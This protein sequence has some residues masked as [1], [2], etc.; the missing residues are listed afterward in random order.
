MEKQYSTLNTDIVKKCHLIV[1]VKSTSSSSSETVKNVLANLQAAG[2]RVAVRPASETTIFVFVQAPEPLIHDL[3]DEDRKESF[4]CGLL[5]RPEDMDS[6]GSCL[7]EPSEAL[8][9]VFERLT[10]LQ[11]KVVWEWALGARLIRTLSK[12][13]HPITKHNVKAHLGS[14]V[15]LYFAFMQFYFLNLVV[16]SAWGVFCYYFLGDYS[17]IFAFGILL[18]GIFFAQAWKVRERSLSQ[19]WSINGC[20]RKEKC[21]QEFKPLSFKVDSFTGRARP[22]FPQWETVLRTLP[23]V[24]LLLVSGGV[25]LGL[26]AGI[27]ALEVYLVELYNGPLKFLLTLLPTVAFQACTI[28]FFM[29]YRVAAKKLT[30]LENRRTEKEY[31]M[32]FSRKVF[33]FN[34]MVS[35]TA[36][37]LTAYVYGPFSKR[38]VAHYSSKLNV[39]SRFHTDSFQGNPLRLRSQFLYFLTNAQLI[40]FITNLLVP[41]VLRA[42]KKLIKQK[43]KS[44]P[45][46]VI[47]DDE[48]E[49]E[50]LESYRAQS[51]L[52]PYDSYTDYREMIIQFGYVVMFSPI[53]PLAPVFFLVNNFFEIRGDMAKITNEMQRPL[54]SLKDSIGLWN[55]CLQ[56][57]SWLG[58]M[59]LTSLCYYYTSND[60]FSS[61]SMPIA[62]LIALFAEHVWVL[63][64]YFAVSILPVNEEEG[65][66][67]A[68]RKR[69][70]EEHPLSAEKRSLEE[71]SEEIDTSVF[72]DA[73]KVLDVY[74]K[75]ETK[76]D[77]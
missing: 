18:W 73:E 74:L 58:S 36:L 15:S 38:I 71:K 3:V 14:E 39:F 35:Y 34:F 46:I 16:P 31:A 61:K 5:N 13:L 6:Y 77:R 17:F 19:R 7:I 11:K 54:P 42:V 41:A 1:E 64:R 70:L 32:S 23:T 27:F 2:F 29:I 76:K 75:Q 51:E 72:V 48:L 55:Q 44:V 9:V 4:L 69:Y 57:L 67:Y 50:V 65:Q 43:R 53:F 20:D 52:P 12:S 45:S 24:P 49:H 63:L 66:P 33:L 8:R 62:M 10:G 56:L 28:P 59:T 21:V 68:T 40:N 26:L 25:L 30:D 60:A 37:F 47:Q 22:F